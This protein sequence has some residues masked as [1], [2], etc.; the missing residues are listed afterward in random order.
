MIFINIFP[1]S[2]PFHLKVCSDRNS[3]IKKTPLGLQNRRR[4]PAEVDSK[5]NKKICLGFQKVGEFVCLGVRHEQTF[6]TLHEVEIL[7]LRWIK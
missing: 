4:C 5:I 6:T 1:P 2:P 3:Q 7:L